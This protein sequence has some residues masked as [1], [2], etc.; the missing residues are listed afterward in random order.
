MANLNNIEKKQNIKLPIEYIK[1]YESNFSRINS[2]AKIQ[3]G[4]NIFSIQRFL[5]ANEIIDALDENYN[6]WGYDF[7][8]I[9]ETNYTDYICLYYKK[10]RDK[11]TIVYWNYELALEDPDDCISFLYNNIH[12]FLSNLR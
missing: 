5:Y 4:K 8:P 11:P 12:E 10:S 9:A 2:N 3:L 6:F 7:I 1:L